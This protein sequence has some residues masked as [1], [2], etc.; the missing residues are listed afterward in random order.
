MIHHFLINPAAGKGSYTEALARK[1]RRACSNCGVTYCIYTTKRPGD[2]TDYVRAAVAEN[3][4]E[5]HRFYACGGDGTLSETINGAPCAENAEFAVIPIGT[6]NDFECNFT[7]LD[8]FF[9][10]ERQINGRVVKID[11]LRCNDRYAL[12]MINIGFD[13]NV[14]KK[15]GEIKRSP[16]VPT[17]LAYVAGVAITFCKPFGT[18]MD[19]TLADGTHIHDSL[20]LT[21]IAN[22]AFCGG[23]FKATP[24]A[25]LTDGLLDICVIN[26]VTRMKFLQLIG[27]YKKGTHLELPMAQDVIRYYQTPSVD[28]KFDAPLGICIDGEIEMNDHINI[29]IVPHALSFSIPEGSGLAEEE[30]VQAETEAPVASVH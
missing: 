2:A 21:A 24:R 3:P 15:T 7:G 8:N 19:I 28:F 23:G 6:G 20:M 11:I 12:N 14:A 13:S 1:I 17:G 29:S 26:K 5:K 9:D 18:K 10:I 27:S 22:G 30:A 16:M 4:N 25:S